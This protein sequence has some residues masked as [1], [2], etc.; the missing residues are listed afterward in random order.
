M[1]FIGA[2]S[3]EFTSAEKTKLS[4]IETSATADQTASEIRSLIGTGNNNL[5]PAAGSAGQFL[6]HDGTFGT[7][8]YTTNTDTQLTTE[9]VQDIVGGMLGGTET[10]I[11]VTYDD[12]NGR[13][14]FVVDDMT[15]D[16][17][18]QLSNAE[19]RSAVEAASD[20][21][22]FTD[23]DHTKL[24]NI[25]TS[26]DVTDA[27]NVAAAGALMDS[28]LL[29]ED[30]MSTN[31]ATKP[32]SQQSIKAYA[33]RPKKAIKVYHANFKD[34]SGTTPHFIPLAAVPDE[35]TSE[36]KEH[37]TLIMPAAG[38]VKEIILRTHF[39]G[40]LVAD[41]P[42]TWRVFTRSKEKKMNDAGAEVG[43]F[44]MT[45][46][47]NDANNVNNTQSSGELS[48]AFAKHDALSIS[49]EWANAGPTDSSN[50]DRMYVTV[51]TE[52]DYNSLGY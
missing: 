43:N 10:R 51:V 50:R 22:V 7:P 37:T 29:D 26:A 16:T 31:S 21:N 46:P 34:G 18:T 11:G 47:T 5:V 1:K 12:S 8:S 28:D 30:D 4:G 9:E 40:T 49:M 36:A 6:K 41:D 52:M 19:V 32:A 17:N 25:E 23:A 44:T 38:N 48:L 20:S 33:D 14:D 2:T 42:I 3:S 24:N 13:I 45:N 27:T 35:Q 15:A 39:F